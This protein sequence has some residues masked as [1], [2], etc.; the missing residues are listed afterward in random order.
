[1]KSTVLM[2]ERR[3]ETGMLLLTDEQQAFLS[4]AEKF[5]NSQGFYTEQKGSSVTGYRD[6][7][8]VV[9][10]IAEE[11]EEVEEEIGKT[12]NVLVFDRGEM[13][14][15]ILMNREEPTG[16]YNAQMYFGGA[17]STVQFLSAEEV[18]EVRARFRD[19]GYIEVSNGYW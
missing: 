3:D 1:M 19:D 13:V 6:D 18:E 2:A 11:V 14:F 5:F 16:V 10:G 9:A 15:S 7:L 4:A 17:H 8:I 12:V